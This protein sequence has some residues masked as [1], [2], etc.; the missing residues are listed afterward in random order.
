MDLSYIIKSKKDI[1]NV[2]D[3]KNIDDLDYKALDK[4]YQEANRYYINEISKGFDLVSEF[5]DKGNQW[6]SIK[7]EIKPKTTV[8]FANQPVY[9]FIRTYQNSN[10]NNKKPLK[11]INLTKGYI[12]T[13]V[14][15]YAEI[16]PFPI[17]ISG[18]DYKIDQDI[19][20]KINLVLKNIFEEENNFD[21]LYETIMDT[22]FKYK[23]CFV[24]PVIDWDKSDTQTPIKLRIIKPEE[25]RFDFTVTNINESDYVCQDI[26]LRYRDLKKLW[27]YKPKPDEDVDD[28]EIIIIRQW[29]FRNKNHEGKVQ[30]FNFTVYKDK[31]LKPLD[32]DGKVDPTLIVYDCLPL[33]MFNSNDDLKSK[34]IAELIIPINVDYNIAL[35]EQNWNM[36]KW[37]NRPKKI[38]GNIDSGNIDEADIP[39]GKIVIP[40]AG[41]DVQPYQVD[42]MDINM[43]EGIKQILKQEIK[44]ATGID[45]DLLSGGKPKG[46][47]SNNLLQTLQSKSDNYINMIQKRVFTDVEELAW[48]SINMLWKYLDGKSLVL[49]NPKILGTTVIYSEDLLDTR[50]KLKI[51]TK[52]TNLMTKETKFQL[53]TQF[54]QY[55]QGNPLLLYPMAQ[56][57]NNA[58]PHIFPD[59][60]IKVFK[61]MYDKT[62]QQIQSPPIQNTPTAGTS[63]SSIPAPNEIQQV[64]NLPDSA[65]GDIIEQDNI[66]NDDPVSIDQLMNEWNNAEDQLREVGY[67][68]DEINNFAE[69]L[70]FNPLQDGTAKSDILMSIR[71]NVDKSINNMNKK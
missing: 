51:D 12:Q 28:M 14:A 3:L 48:K 23:Y 35:T 49:F 20:D 21:E 68:D 65:G 41:A 71:E 19:L 61:D 26:K 2:K 54:M 36:L 55:S 45:F 67:N 47:Y 5:I 43:V 44:E 24:Q 37:F 70:L 69:K 25:V 6:S 11:S 4:I 40:A 53:L 29:W 58:I 46:T 39:G 10:T 56:M 34:S 33:V 62:V 22:I 66:N 16:D 52:D 8:N 31:W 17:A 64:N 63:G 32:I 42:I 27:D 15:N 30:W 7:D 1:E 13:L 60:T 18:D 59:E 38:I 9:D 50:I 57:T